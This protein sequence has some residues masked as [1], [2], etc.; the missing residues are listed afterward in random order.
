M[1]KIFGFMVALTFSMQAMAFEQDF[2]FFGPD[3]SPPFDSIVCKAGNTS[4][5]IE[6][7]HWR[8]TVGAGPALIHANGETWIGGWNWKAAPK[9]TRLTGFYILTV[10]SSDLES[11]PFIHLQA[12]DSG[13]GQLGGWLEMPGISGSVDCKIVY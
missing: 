2:D 11:G 1:D 9:G 13:S 6:V 4:V 8:Q 7:K 10:K 3:Y 5:Q 12:V